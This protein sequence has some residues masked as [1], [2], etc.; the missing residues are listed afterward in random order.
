MWGARHPGQLDQGRNASAR[1]THFWRL[2]ERPEPETLPEHLSPDQAK[3][4]RMSDLGNFLCE[5]RVDGL[6][7]CA[8][9]V[10]RRTRDRIALNL[11]QFWRAVL[12]EEMAEGNGWTEVRFF[13]ETRAV[14]LRQWWSKQVKIVGILRSTK[15]HFVGSD[16]VLGEL[17]ELWPLVTKM[18][19]N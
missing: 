10:Q 11:A 1:R 13:C 16:F 5:P 17:C 18:I 7:A 19:T 3:P 12:K 8:E 9:H 4:E 14:W 2:S 15:L 6:W